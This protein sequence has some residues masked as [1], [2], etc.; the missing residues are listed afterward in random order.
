MDF[1]NNVENG[2]RECRNQLSK[3]FLEK[4][5]SARG[6]ARNVLRELQFFDKISSEIEELEE[7]LI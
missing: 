6:Q 1:M 5:E 7:R 3:L 2:K 4:S